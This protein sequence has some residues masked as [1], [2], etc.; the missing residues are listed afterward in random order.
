MTLPIAR[1]ATLLAATILLAG[2]VSWIAPLSDRTVDRNHGTR[3]L[4]SKIE[5]EAIERKTYLNI[6]RGAPDLA[7]ARLVATSW[8]GQLLLVGQV[9]SDAGKQ[10]AEAIARD[11]RHVLHVHN[12]L[13]VGAPV[14][15]LVRMSDGWI[16]TRVKARLLF[17]PDVPGRRVKVVTENGVVYLMGLLTREESDTVVNAARGVY[18]VQ[19][20]VKIFE[21]VDPARVPATGAPA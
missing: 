2:C 10:R 4:G 15:L 8:N 5:D 12:E 3:T 9:P 11:V 6:V 17:G 20:I 16:T 1:N 14:S 21:Y 18:G 19:K 13:V 7:Q